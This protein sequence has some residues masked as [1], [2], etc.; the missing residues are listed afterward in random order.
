MLTAKISALIGFDRLVKELDG[1]PERY[2]VPYQLTTT[3]LYHPNLRVPLQHL[4]EILQLAATDLG[5]PELGMRLG[6][7]QDFSVLGASGQSLL[8]SQT[9]LDALYAARSVNT[10]HNQAEY[11][12]PIVQGGQVQF[13]RYDLFRQ[14][15]DT[16]Q[17]KEMAMAACYNLGRILLSEQFLDITVEFEHS[18]INAIETYRHYFNCPVRFNCEQDQLLIPKHIAELPLSVPRDLLQQATNL[19]TQETSP[20]RDVD[21]NQ[22]VAILIQ[23][24]MSSGNLSIDNVAQMM[25]MSKRSLQRKLKHQGTEFKTL[26][27]S[28]RIE[29]ACWYLVSSQIDITLISEIVGY[30]DTANFSRAFKRVV[31]EPPSV[32]RAR[33]TQN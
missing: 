28:I 21:I 6:A 27:E 14:V 29:K 33:Q 23:Q 18:P 32:W 17:Y 26:V 11:W 20:R 24:L 12:R 7:S 8:L 30:T 19:P 15:Y 1:D 13:R 31:G 25:A 3:D 10:Y 2:L 9:L 22:D 16:R 4:V 5:C